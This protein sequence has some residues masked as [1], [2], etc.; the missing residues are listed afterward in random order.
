M[1]WLMSWKAFSS[2]KDFG[3]VVLKGRLGWGVGHRVWDQVA[4]SYSR[5]SSW[6][7]DSTCVSCISRQILYHSITYIPIKIN[8]LKSLV[9]FYKH[10]WEMFH[11]M[12]LDKRTFPGLLLCTRHSSSKRDPEKIA[13]CALPSRSLESYRGAFQKSRVCLCPGTG[14]AEE[15]TETAKAVER[16]ARWSGRIRAASQAAGILTEFSKLWRSSPGREEEK[17][18]SRCKTW[19]KRYITNTKGQRPKGSVTGPC[20]LW[21]G[22][23]AFLP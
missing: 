12:S 9:L 22:H 3:K 13:T 4:I 18:A 15:T 20:R 19:E 8:F 21:Q 5:G 16:K 17:R 11:L 10:L 2:P 7:R 6:P 14:L 23:G 1:R